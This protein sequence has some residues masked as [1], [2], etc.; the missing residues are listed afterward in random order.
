MLAQ[1]A[2]SRAARG[3]RR[4]SRR[5]GR[6]CRHRSRRCPR[7][8]RPPSCS[9]RSRRSRRAGS[10]GPTPGAVIPRPAG[11]GARARRA[12]RSRSAL[13]GRDQRQPR[14][15]DR[16]A[17]QLDRG[18]D[19]DRVD[20]HRERLVAAATA[21]RPAPGR[22]RGR[23]RRTPRPAPACRRP[24]TC[25]ATQMPPQPPTSP[26][27]SSRSSL[28]AYSARPPSTIAPRLVDVGGGLLDGDHVVDLGEAQQQLG[29]QVD[30]DPLRDVVDDDRQV[31]GHVGDRAEVAV[32]AL[33]R[34][35]RVVRRDDQERRRR[36]PRAPRASGAPSARVS[37]VPVV[38]I[39]DARSPTSSTTASI[40][41]TR[42]TS[43]TR[44]ALAG[45][46]GEHEALAA[47]GDEVAGQRAGDVEVERRRPPP[48]GV[49]MAV[50]I[51]P[52][53]GSHAG[54]LGMGPRVVCFTG[55]SPWVRVGGSCSGVGLI[56][57][58]AAGAAQA[59]SGRVR[60]LNAGP[61]GAVTLVV[62]GEGDGPPS[63]PPAKVS[64]RFAVAA[65]TTRSGRARHATVASRRS[66]VESG[67]RLTVVLHGDRWPRRCCDCCASPRG[68]GDDHASG[69]RTTR[70]TPALVD[71]RVGGLAVAR[72]LDYSRAMVPAGSPR[73]SS[74]TGLATVTAVAHAGAVLTAAQPLVL[75]TRS[76]GIFATR[77]AR[78]RLAP[79]P[80]RVR[81]RAA[82]ADAASRR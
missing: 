7:P 38:A 65:G 1:V 20:R 44:R 61:S 79:D 81:H 66:R 57:L 68:G 5:A 16:E 56:A 37:Y 69:S 6:R 67:E 35:L 14:L 82:D 8:T 76:V 63:S 52:E 43:L 36:R 33:G 21:R 23:P 74:P 11:R 46:P 25:E 3:R 15:A 77:A 49:T 30:D 32:D 28:P 13:G 4:A 73:R 60:A 78:P 71:V 24:A 40:S 70:A 29:R 10:R 62:D 26:N 55:F 53:R 48:K 51:R 19:R 31:A 64:R 80:A 47:V 72:G 39:T 75:A 41:W 2:R 17:E 9:C 12:R 27:G 50:M 54:S 42:S 22:A 34:R 58:L 59:A 45:R 18:L